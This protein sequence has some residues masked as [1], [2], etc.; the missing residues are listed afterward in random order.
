MC[1]APLDMATLL[2]SRFG[3]MKYIS[4]IKRPLHHIIQI[5][6]I[7][8]SWIGLLKPSYSQKFKSKEYIYIN[9]VSQKVG[10]AANPP[11]QS[12]LTH[13]LG[14]YLGVDGLGWTGLDWFWWTGGLAAHPT[15]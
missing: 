2:S 14:R 4:T 11:I 1:T 8:N 13:R 9:I 3:S 10:Y 5:M 6:A 12:N 7:L 15:F